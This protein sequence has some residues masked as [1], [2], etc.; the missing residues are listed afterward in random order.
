MYNHQYS[1]QA[2]EL[3]GNRPLTPNPFVEDEQ[4]DFT[5]AV[6]GTQASGIESTS[7]SEIDVYL[8]ELVAT[9]K[10]LYI[11]ILFVVI[12]IF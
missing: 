9:R 10:V 11:E 3:N 5:E 12:V 8:E 6:F 7:V 2:L 1:A 4:D